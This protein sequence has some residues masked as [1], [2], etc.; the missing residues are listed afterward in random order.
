M[1]IAV[2]LSNDKYFKIRLRYELEGL[3]TDL[4]DAREALARPDAVAF[5]DTDTY[6]IAPL[7]ESALTFSRHGGAD[8]PIPFPLGA[9]ERL[10]RGRTK[11]TARLTLLSDGH[12]AL[13]DARAVRLSD[14][15]FSLLS[16]LLRAKG[17]Y[18]D[19]QTLLSELWNGEDEGI[20]NV[21]IHYLRKKLETENEKVILSARGKGYGINPAYLSSDTVHGQ[22]P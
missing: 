18:V 17:E 22:E 16:R 20:L 21:Y 3:F 9:A 8:L 5:I 13:L 15:E 19:R 4:S 14:G 12:T 2:I 1:P 6:P 10:L 7:P 11:K